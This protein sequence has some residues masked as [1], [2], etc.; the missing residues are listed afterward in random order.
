MCTVFCIVRYRWVFVECHLVVENAWSRRLHRLAKSLILYYVI[1]LSEDVDFNCLP[2]DQFLH[3][4]K[5]KAF[6]DEK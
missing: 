2:N 4:S 3:R 6:A 1:V 5:L